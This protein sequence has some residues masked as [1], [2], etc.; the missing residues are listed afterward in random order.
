MDKYFLSEDF[1]QKLS[2]YQTACREESFCDL[3]MDDLGDIIQYY[4]ELD[5]PQEA[6][7]AIDFALSIYPDATK[8]LCYKARYALLIEGNANKAK[9]IANTIVDQTDIDY[10]FLKAEI[11]LYTGEGP[12]RAHDL[13]YKEVDQ[14]FDSEEKNDYCLDVAR[15]FADYFCFSL[16]DRW[17]KLCTDE[18]DDLYIEVSYKILRFTEQW[19]TCEKLLNKQLDRDPYNADL[20]VELAAVQWCQ[21]HYEDSITSCEYALAIEPE[22][23]GAIYGKA[24]GL[25]TL[26]NYE[27][28][29]AAFDRCY[30][31]VKPN[32]QCKINV[33]RGYVYMAMKNVEQAHFYLNKAINEASDPDEVRLEVS[34]VLIDTELYDEAYNL[35]KTIK[36]GDDLEGYYCYLAYCCFKLNL[37][38]EYNIYLQMAY[39]CDKE[40]AKKI[41]SDLFSEE[42]KSF[43]DS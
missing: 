6:L 32:Q 15:L 39:D 27:D 34:M 13:L 24:T 1:K 33:I 3:D 28:A 30:S 37:E 29:L 7:Q 19:E 2:S 20:W 41:L 21:K 16:A 18:D 8:A 26:G 11:I 9:Q 10:L 38:S 23:W 12:Q 36:T 42:G 43:L 31:K 22:H 35:L 40:I 25:C 5:Q 14:L 4:A 17:L